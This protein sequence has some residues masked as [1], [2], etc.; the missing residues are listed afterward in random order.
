M[1]RCQRANIRIKPSKINLNVKNADILGL[2]W[3]KGT[4]TPTNHKLDPLAHC[5]KPRTVKGLRSFLGAV[6]F[7]EICLN[8]KDLADATEHLDAIIPA[9]KQGSELIEWNDLLNESFTKVQEV[10][11]NPLKIYVPKRDDHLYIIGD[12]APSKGPGIGISYLSKDKDQ[13]ICSHHST[14]AST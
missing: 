5:D 2:H 12:A 7:N 13:N 9:S 6:R 11:K 3:N 1:E 14:L 10:C 4:L 8:S